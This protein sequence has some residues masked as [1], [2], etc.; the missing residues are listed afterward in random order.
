ML[1][2]AIAFPLI[3]SQ[4]PEIV[5]FPVFLFGGGLGGTP[6]VLAAFEF[7]MHEAFLVAAVVTVF[8]AIISFSRPSGV[9]GDSVAA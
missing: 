3:L 8:A 4:I 7:G 2:I 6:Q 5:L 9:P 1:S